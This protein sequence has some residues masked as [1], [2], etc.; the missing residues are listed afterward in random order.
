MTDCPL[1]GEA[2]SRAFFLFMWKGQ[3]MVRCT[4]CELIYKT[5]APSPP[6]QQSFYENNYYE[7]LSDNLPMINLARVPLY[8]EAL[9]QFAGLKR[10]G[11]LLDIGSGYGDFLKLAKEDGWDAWGIEPSRAASDAA[12]QIQGIH[13]FT[14]TVEQAEFPAN[15]FDIVTLWNVVDCLPDPVEVMRRVYEWLAPGGTVIIRTP[16]TS[17]HLQIHRIY[18]AFKPMLHALGW[19]KEASVFL[20]SNFDAST[21]KL[22][23][24]RAGF[25]SVRMRNSKPTLGDAY[26]VF[27]LSFLMKWAKAVVFGLAGW[28]GCLSGHRIF[29]GPSLYVTAFKNGTN[30]SAFDPAIEKRVVIKRWI[31][32]A[33]A[34]CGY[35]FLL[36]L[37]GKLLRKDRNVRILLYHSVDTAATG[38]MTVTVDEFEKH[39]EFIR[40]KYQVLPLPHAVS[41]LQK[42]RLPDKPSVVLTFDDGYQDNHRLV[43]PAL[44]RAGLNAAFF[45][46]TGNGQ[47][48]RKTRHLTQAGA[49]EYPLL[50]WEE[51]Q[52]MGATGMEIGSHGKSH[53]GLLSLSVDALEQELRDS[54]RLIEDK[55][56]RPVDFFSYPYGTCLDFDGRTK[57]YAKQAGYKAALSKVFGTNGLGADLFALKRI[58]VEASDTLFTLRAKLN[59]ALDLLIFFDLPW[60]RKI[61]RTLN[62]WVFSATNREKTDPILLVS[63]DFPPHTDGVSTISRELS[64][65][66]ANAG[67]FMMVIGPQDKGASEFDA[68]Q[69]YRAYRV[70]GYEWGYLRFLPIFLTMPWVV[71][72]HGITKVYAM[73][74]AYGGFLAW[75]LSWVRPLEYVIFAYGYEFEKVKKNFLARRL[76]LDIYRRAKEIVCCSDLVRQRL[77]DFGVKDR[78]IEVLYPAVDLDRYKPATVPEGYLTRS[79]LSGRRILL[80]V[81]RLVQRKG[82]DRVFLALPEIVK[83]VPD[84][85]YCVVGIGEYESALREKVKQLKLEP[86]VRFMGKLQERELIYLYNACEIFIMPSREIAEGGHIEGFGI[87]FLEANACKKPVIGGRSGGVKE[88]IQDG[89]TGLLVDPESPRDIA[90]KVI[91]L[92]KDT[93]KARRMGEQG[94]EWVRQNFSWERYVKESYHL[95][96]GKGLS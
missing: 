46:L 95:L 81:G 12:S 18:S 71:L 43:Y 63:V 30:R 78:K 56:G 4:S 75:L 92:L 79:G 65:R 17:F 80:T 52:E 48:D 6:M 67:H 16:N 21:M 68:E 55:T 88:A 44:K 40:Q 94:F 10:T 69:K 42:G 8:K 51:A 74:I 27:T 32:Y 7:S 36:P 37:W 54:K 93:D 11:R 1:C 15:H 3:A 62:H 5:E 96:T 91:S 23:L 59:G 47:D 33:L 14:G 9:W 45:V 61:V 87:V 50:S 24:K 84:V 29:M 28:V 86:Y 41:G 53:A 77:I 22:L 34:V 83:S 89:V 76:Y 49:T 85:V 31:L 39:L 82:H 38:D 70:P 2:V 19:K 73:N 25:D 66:I 72:R 64:V 35:F 60:V 57:F 13:S 20:R 26:R 90:A 58:G